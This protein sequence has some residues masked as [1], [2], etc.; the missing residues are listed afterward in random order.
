MSNFNTIWPVA[1]F[2]LGAALTQF[3]SYLTE[4]R[5]RARDVESRQYESSRSYLEGKKNFEIEVLTD[6]YKCLTALNDAADALSSWYRSSESDR[7][8]E[9]AHGL[10]LKLQEGTAEA[11]RLNGLLFDSTLNRSVGDS[12]GVELFPNGPKVIPG[13]DSLGAYG[14]GVWDAHAQVAERLKKLYDRS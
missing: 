11:W 7:D 13:E 1:S 5:Q 4:R 14:D 2:V 9:V 6:L 8:V 12:I 3:N 10:C